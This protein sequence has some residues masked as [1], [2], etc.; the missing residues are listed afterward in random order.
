[1]GSGVGAKRPASETGAEN[2]PEGIDGS[3]RVA[4]MGPFASPR[5]VTGRVWPDVP[6][7]P[8]EG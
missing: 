4:G 8:P 3:W 5:K 7:W 6:D 1:M 2:G